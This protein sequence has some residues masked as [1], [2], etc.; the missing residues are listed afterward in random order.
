[1][2]NYLEQTDALLAS[3]LSDW[4]FLT[5]ILAVVIAGLLAYPFLF[6]EEPDTHPLLLARQSSS[7][8]VRNKNESAAYRSPEVPYGTSLKSGLNVRDA[9]APRWASGKDGDLRDVWREVLRGGSVGD[10]GKEVPKGLV[11]TVLGREELVEHDI[12]DLSREIGIIGRHLKQAGVKSVA[13]YLPNGPEYLLTIFSC[14]FYGLTSVLLPYNQPHPKVFEL[15]NSAGADALICAAGNLP[16][17]GVAKECR[18]LKLLT[19]VVEKTSRHMDWNGVPG[20][21]EG[22]LKVSVWHDL[23]DNQKANASADLPSNDHGDKPGDVVAVWQPTNPAAKPEIVT[24]TQRNIVAATAALIT[25]LP[26]RQRFTSADLVVPADSFTH[27]YVLCQTF[28]ALYTHASLAITSVASSGVELSTASRLVSPTVIIASAETLAG[29]HTK[30]T[31]GVTTLAQKVGKYSHSQ[32]MEAGRMPTDNLLFQLL[33]PPSSSAGNTPGKLRLI[34]TS[35]RLGAGS[36]V[37]TSTMVSDLRILT[38]SRICYA[39]TAAQVAGAIAQTNVFDY[40]RVDGSANSHFGV[41]LSSVE[42]RLASKADGEVAGP[43]PKGE[44]IVSGPAVSGGQV[45]LGVRGMIRED[46]TVAYA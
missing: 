37:L 12:T 28:A 42:I 8:P 19:W 40:R 7:A 13:I 11:M 23:V 20:A 38:R 16:L 34:L 45:R 30:E 24:F 36:P 4:G 3:F 15:I 21:A 29:L 9:G 26:L 35:E 31:Q 10:D 39:L 32:A 6:A 33:A 27:T 44:M 41:P 43:E 17:D 18:R 46:G 25:A 5:T 1:M 2:S 14:A 22:R